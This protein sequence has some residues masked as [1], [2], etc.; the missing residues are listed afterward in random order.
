MAAARAEVKRYQFIDFPSAISPSPHAASTFG[1]ATTF[2]ASSFCF[3]ATTNLA[4]LRATHPRFSRK[5]HIE[6]FVRRFTLDHLLRFVL[7]F[8]LLP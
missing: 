8:P 3:S 6:G 4:S 7:S 5:S 2:S 1:N